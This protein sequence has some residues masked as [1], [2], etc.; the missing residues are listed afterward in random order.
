MLE[1][2]WDGDAPFAPCAEGRLATAACD[3]RGMPRGVEAA[4]HGGDVRYRT[5]FLQVGFQL[6]RAGFSFLALDEE[7]SGRVDRNLLAVAIDRFGAR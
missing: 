5:R 2:A 6:G 4:R 3:L 1:G 7:G